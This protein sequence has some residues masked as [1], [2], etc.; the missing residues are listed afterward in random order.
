[1]L[2]RFRGE[3]RAKDTAE[4]SYRVC[5]SGTNSH[6]GLPWEQPKAP[7]PPERHPGSKLRGAGQGQAPVPLG[8]GDPRIFFPCLSLASHL[9]VKIPPMTA[10]RELSS[11][12]IPL[13]R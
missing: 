6:D 12:S 1:M 8:T 2:L 4:P 9:Q 5:S 11:R 13:A 3:E 10:A 7:P